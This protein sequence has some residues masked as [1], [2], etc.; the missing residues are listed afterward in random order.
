MMSS[1][2]LKEMLGKCLKSARHDAHVTDIPDSKT[3]VTQRCDTE[4]WC[5]GAQWKGRAVH[6][7]RGC[8]GEKQRDELI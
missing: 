8:E 6:T 2:R 3:K 4:K 1:S 5:D 7:R